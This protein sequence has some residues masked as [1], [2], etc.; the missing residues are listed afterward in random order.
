M[1]AAPHLQIDDPDWHEAYEVHG[2][3][4]L[5]FLV[6][7]LA[8]PEDAEDLLQETFVRA[9]RSGQA[10]RDPAKLRPYLFTIAN[11]LVRNRFRQQRR[12]R[13]RE[14]QEGDALRLDEVPSGPWAAPDTAADL[15]F[16][17]SRVERFVRELPPHHRQAFELAVLRQESYAEIARRTGWTIAQVKINVYRARR[18]AVIALADF[19]PAAPGR[20]P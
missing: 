6:S 3:A 17:E 18:K 13:G 11:N 5:S 9:I 19:L 16:L 2:T 1:G 7:R 12:G 10:L 8:R 15:H 4:V 20:C 14:L